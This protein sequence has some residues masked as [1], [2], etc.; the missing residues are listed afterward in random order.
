VTRYVILEHTATE[1]SNVWIP[2]GEVDAVSASA[3]I[4]KALDGHNEGGEF[5]AVPARSWK[6][7]TVA[8]ETKTSLKFQ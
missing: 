6:P 3:A 1:G 5:V 4:K 2:S 7:V 8:V